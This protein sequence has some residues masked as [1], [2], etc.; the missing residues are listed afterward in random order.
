MAAA[1]PSSY[2]RGGLA[3]RGASGHQPAGLAAGKTAA[4]SDP[5]RQLSQQQQQQQQRNERGQ[6]GAGA[7]GGA[8]GGPAQNTLAQVDITEEQREEILEAVSLLRRTADARQVEKW[9]SCGDGEKGES[10]RLTSA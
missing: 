5:A 9:R 7:G 3:Y 2:P 6:G 10:G 4:I 8:L 1:G